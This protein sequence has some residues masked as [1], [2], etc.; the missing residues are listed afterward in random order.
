MFVLLCYTVREVSD[1]HSRW[2][3]M[4]LRSKMRVVKDSDCFVFLD[5]LKIAIK[6]EQ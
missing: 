1:N 4:C 5:W 3:V 6:V 2:R